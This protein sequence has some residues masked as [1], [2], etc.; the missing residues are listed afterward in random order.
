MS[1]A[2]LGI[3]GRLPNPMVERRFS[4]EYGTPLY[5]DARDFL[6]N[7]VLAGMENIDFFHNSGANIRIKCLEVHHEYAR[8]SYR[9]E[10]E[11]N[12][13]QEEFYVIAE[14]FDGMEEMFGGRPF[15]VQQLREEGR[16]PSILYQFTWCNLDVETFFGLCP[17][18]RV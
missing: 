2:R 4:E 3:F 8:F 17:C 1:E 12:I 18:H 16:A 9:R 7:T 5:I 14:A 6:D 15:S 10:L 13:T 11:G